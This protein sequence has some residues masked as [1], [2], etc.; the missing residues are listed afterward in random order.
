MRPEPDRDRE[1]RAALLVGLP[2]ELAL[3]LR[4]GLARLELERDR[5]PARLRRRLLGER[6]LRA[7]RVLRRD[8]ERR[9][10]T[11]PVS[12]IPASLNRSVQTPFRFPP[13]NAGV[14]SVAGAG[15][16]G[17]SAARRGRP[18]GARREASGRAWRRPRPATTR[19][20]AAT[21]PDRRTCRAPAMSDES[22][23]VPA[24]VMPVRLK[25][26]WNAGKGGMRMTSR[27]PTQ[28]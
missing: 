12:P 19:R 25:I 23:Q 8:R 27:S 17:A 10:L 2:A 13:A 26:V 9:R 22:P 4:P 24:V 7:D 21:R 11:V 1:G 14:R 6:R 20:S 28:G 3:E 18:V 16:V 15:L 5:A